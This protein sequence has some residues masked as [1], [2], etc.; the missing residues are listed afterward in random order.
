MTLHR[1]KIVE[2]LGNGFAKSDTKE[3]QSIAQEVVAL[4]LKDFARLSAKLAAT[5]VSSLPDIKFPL[6]RACFANPLKWFK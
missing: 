4:R 5:S 6:G 2:G 3:L 1:L